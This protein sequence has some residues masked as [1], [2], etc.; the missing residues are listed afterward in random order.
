MVDTKNPDVVYIM[1]TSVYRSTDGG[2]NF[3]GFK[4]APGGDD[5]H[6]NLDRSDRP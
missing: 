1:N 2:A 3:A 5:Y 6:F 4:G